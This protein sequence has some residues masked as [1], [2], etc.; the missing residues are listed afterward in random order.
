[1]ETGREENERGKRGR[2]YKGEG[3]MREQGRKVK[4]MRMGEIRRKGE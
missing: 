1:M 4:K 2:V 3:R